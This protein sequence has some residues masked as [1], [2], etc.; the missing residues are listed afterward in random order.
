MTLFFFSSDTLPLLGG[1]LW[2]HGSVE[3]KYKR[4][5]KGAKLV[6]DAPTALIE[7]PSRM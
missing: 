5:V 3:L 7:L 1:M 6:L 2:D 4:L